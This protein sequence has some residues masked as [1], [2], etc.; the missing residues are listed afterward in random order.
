MFFFFPR[1]WENL[2][3]VC[4]YF[5]TRLQPM[6]PS[7]KKFLAGF[8]PPWK[9]FGFHP[10]PLLTLASKLL[11]P[12]TR[13]TD[14]GPYLGNKPYAA[15]HNELS[16]TRVTRFCE[17][18]R[19]VVEFSLPDFLRKRGLHGRVSC[20]C[21][22]LLTAFASVGPW[23]KTWQKG[24]GMWHSFPARRWSITGKIT[25]KAWFGGML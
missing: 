19:S 16:W 9:E 4:L 23:N 22:C 1:S 6:S 7:S 8:S 13:Y 25:G 3:H 20:L 18:L 15:M 2:S 12:L 5:W 10:I 17:H 11:L 21:L 14:R 24:L